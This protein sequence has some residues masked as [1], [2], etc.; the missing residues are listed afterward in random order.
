MPDKQIFFDPQRKRW[1]RLRRILDITAVVSTLVLAGFI[2]NVLR[3][4]HL[5]EL[6]LPTPEAQLQGVCKTGRQPARGQQAGRPARRK[7]DRKPSEIPFN[8]GEGLR[9]A[10]YVPYDAASYSSLKEHVHQI[11]LLFPA[12][13]ARRCAF[14]LTC[15]EPPPTATS[16]RSSKAASVHDPDDINKIKRVIQRPREDT[17]I[18]PH[19]NNY[20]AHTQSWDP[21]MGDVLKD[22]AKRSRSA[23]RSCASSP[24]FPPIA[25]SRSTSKILNDDAHP[26]YLAFIQELYADLHRA[27]SASLCQRAG[28]QRRPTISSHRRQLRRRCADELRRARSRERSGADRQPGL[29]R[30]QS[31]P[32][33]ETIRAQGE[34]HLRGRQLR[35]RLDDVDSR[36]QGPRPKARKPRVVD[37]EDLPHVSDVWQR[38]SDADADLDLDY[39]S[40]N[41]H[42]EYIDEDTQPAPRGVVSRWRDAAERNA[43]RARSGLA[44]LCAVAARRGR[45]LA[46]EY[47]GQAQRIPRRF[48]RSAF[49]QPG[50]DVDTEG[51]GDILRVTGLP[52][53]RQAHRDR[54]YRRAR[55]AQEAHHRRAHGCVSR[56]PTRSS[57]TAIIPTKLRSRSTTDPIPKWTPKILDILKEK[58]VK[59]TFMMIGEEAQENIGLMQRIQR[60]GHEIGNHTYSIPTSA[61]SRRDRLTSK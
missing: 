1:K 55:P 35:L 4:Q 59:G 22:P 2:F 23:S 33:A 16:S 18:F 56:T 44:D 60:E 29:V 6:L 54:R 43:R 40:L 20:N 36:S 13:A 49:V 52:Q 15:R 30:R 10:Y 37:T 58:N 57:T 31:H 50:H 26:A 28:C 25:A 45:Q 14:A 32:R 53:D 21:A 61:K 51:E 41:P 47:L 24:P 7:T 3:G 12:V 19:L 34:A 38:A 8:T 48:R 46:V 9:A 11:D 17:E 42:F 5:P 27:P 39:D